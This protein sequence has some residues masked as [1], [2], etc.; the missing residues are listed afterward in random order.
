MSAHSHCE[1][2]MNTRETLMKVAGE[3][4]REVG[5][6]DMTTAA[7]AKRAGL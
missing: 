7:V 5:Y 1:E 3:L 2:T 6:D 4:M